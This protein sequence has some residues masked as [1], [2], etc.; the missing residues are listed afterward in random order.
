M[1]RGTSLLKCPCFTTPLIF[2]IHLLLIFLISPAFCQISNPQV[3]KVI[4]LYDSV[5]FHKAITTGDSLLQSGKNFSPDDLALLQQYV[6]FS[7]FN[8]GK[9]DSARTHFLSLLSLKPKI[10][11]DPAETSPKIIEYFEQLRKDYSALT[12]NNQQPVFTKYVISADLRP[13]AAWRSAVLPGWGQFYKGQK[14]RGILLGGAFWGS[15]AAT[16]V[17]VLKEND[18]KDKYEAATD[19]T[20]I[21]RRFDTYNTWFK[22]RRVLTVATVGLWLINVV[23]ASWTTYAQPEIV[24]NQQGEIL[25]S[26]SVS[27]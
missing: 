2:K 1:S 24:V 17:A 10:R 18:R 9:V 25:F 12:P 6:A 13:H 8:I 11:F 3:L 4:Q 14:T 21:S 20:E 7:Y 27:F 22:T 19:P 5:N 15:L 26:A 23:D 16:T